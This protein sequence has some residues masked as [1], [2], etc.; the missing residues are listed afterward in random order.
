M[1]F[2]NE[3]SLLW[4]IVADVGLGEIQDIGYG[5]PIGF[6]Y[7]WADTSKEDPI[8]LSGPDYVDKILTWVEREINDPYLFPTSE[9]MSILL[10]F[11]QLSS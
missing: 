1:D 2:F 10:L 8:R 7:R 4:G 5:F 3:V 6:E 11:H 9:S